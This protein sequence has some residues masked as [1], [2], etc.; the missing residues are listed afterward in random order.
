M[1]ILKPSLQS[2]Y[3]EIEFEN[4]LLGCG[5][6]FIVQHK[7]RFYL[8]TNRHIVTGR[9]NITDKIIHTGCAIP[10]QIGIWHNVSNGLNLAWE[11]RI[12][13]LYNENGQPLWFEHPILGKNA[14][15][16]ALPLTQTQQV[17]LYPYEL[18]KTE[19][20]DLNCTDVVSVIGFPFGISSAGRLAIWATGFIA[21]EFSIP[22]KDLPVFLVDCRSRKGQSGS[23]VVFHRNAGAFNSPKGLVL[24]RGRVE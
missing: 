11:K 9:D 6:G 19:H 24:S 21:S 17:E 10:N 12:E 22:Y 3:L 5:T 2:L 20:E 18:S 16:I 15:F 7:N 4:L 8:L 1:P 23:A 14:D 13:K